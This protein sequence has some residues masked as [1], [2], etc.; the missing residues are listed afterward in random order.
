MAAK[1]NKTRNGKRVVANLCPRFGKTIWSLMLFNEITKKQGNRVMLL[2]AYWLSV[3]S[4]FKG[5]LNSASDFLDI[6]E[7]NPN[8]DTAAEDAEMA[9]AD[10]KRLLIPISL[11]GEFS[12]WATKHEWIANIDNNDIFMFADE[13]DFGTHADN[14]VAKIGYLL[15]GGGDKLVEVYASGTNVQRLAKGAKRVDG[16][17]YTAYSEMEAVEEKM[18]TRRFFAS[19]VLALKDEVETHGEAVQPNWTKIWGK[20]QS[21]KTFI[22]SFVR[23]LFGEDELH[24]E[25][26]ISQMADEDV[27][28]IMV[29]T[30]ANKKEMAQVAKLAEKALGEEY[31][32]QVLNGDFTSNKQAEAETKK[33]ITQGQM[34]SKKGMLILSNT[35]GSRSYS[36]GEI[37]AAVMAFDRGSVDAASQKVSRPLTP[38]NKWNGETKEFGYIVDFSFDPNRAENIEKLIIDEAVQIQRAGTTD[39]FQAAVKFIMNSVDILKVGQFGYTETV[40]EA[41]MFGI[42]GSNENLLKVADITVDV[43]T[44]IDA[45]IFHKLA[46]V[47]ALTSKVNVKEIAGE[48]SKT[49]AIVK[50]EEGERERA[51]VDVDRMKAEKLL[52][53]AIKSLNMSATSVHILAGKD[54]YRECVEALVGHAEFID[55]FGV[56]AELVLELLDIGALNEAILDVIVQNSKTALNDFDF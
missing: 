33:L 7:I 42:L 41:T 5:T 24:P 1:K 11:H 9:L 52:N 38:G 30:S 4:S 27:N 18:I 47:T 23:G 2:P 20:P 51:E 40:D 53:E 35:M 13:G 15:S 16:V 48:N 50:E 43:D 12:A 45:G 55:L 44:I 6:V 37:Q 22:S 36:V 19:N 8:S 29:F 56:D 46:D 34:D 54:S 10:G 17:V 26:N 31:I 25:L 49:R 32:V 21:N 14:Q 28:V 3:H 39:D